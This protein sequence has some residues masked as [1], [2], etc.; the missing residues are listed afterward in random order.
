MAGRASTS[1]IVMPGAT[2]GKSV[3]TTR[4][5][6]NLSFQTLPAVT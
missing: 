6:A 1:R 5:F 4:S 2:V 3:R